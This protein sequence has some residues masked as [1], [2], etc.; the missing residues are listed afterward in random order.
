MKLQ[1]RWATGAGVLLFLLPIGTAAAVPIS[2]G[3]T[4]SFYSD[5]GEWSLSLGE[6]M[7]TSQIHTENGTL[8]MSILRFRR[9]QLGPVVLESRKTP[10][11]Q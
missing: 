3:G 6:R 4:W 8:R 2:M 5:R 1:L 9:W 11:D 7:T 10:V